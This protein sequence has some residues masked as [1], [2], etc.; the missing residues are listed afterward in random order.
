VNR[1]SIP[2]GFTDFDGSGVC[3]VDPVLRNGFPEAI[4]DPVVA[5]RRDPSDEVGVDDS[6]GGGVGVGKGG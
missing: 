2:F 3:V 4:F 1:Y 6:T 5:F